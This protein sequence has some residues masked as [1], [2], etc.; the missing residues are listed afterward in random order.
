VVW[1]LRNVL[2]V[3]HWTKGGRTLFYHLRFKVARFAIGAK[4]PR[5][6][7]V[8]PNSVFVQKLSE[9]AMEVF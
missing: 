5:L 2:A 9:L 8:R 6:G 1:I 4:I 7:L 3:G